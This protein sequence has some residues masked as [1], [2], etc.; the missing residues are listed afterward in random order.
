[1]NQHI[2]L[3]KY[4]Q[5][6]I[7]K[8]ISTIL[9][10]SIIFSFFG[11]K[12]AYAASE[13]VALQ[14][15]KS[16]MIDDKIPTEAIKYANDNF[17]DVLYSSFGYYEHLSSNKLENYSLGKPFVICALDGI[18][19]EIYYFPICL[20]DEI[21]LV[22][23]VIG[24][25]QGY[26]LSA[27]D[28]LVGLLTE[29]KY[30]KS[31]LLLFYKSNDSIKVKTNI[32]TQVADQIQTSNINYNNIV[33]NF[34]NASW[35]ICVQQI[36]DKIDQMKV[37][38]LKSRIAKA[39]D[40]SSAKEAYSPSFSTDNLVGQKGSRICALY[41]PQG[42][43]ALPICWAASVATI[44][45]YR[46]GTNYSAVNVCD[47]MGLS[48]SGQN[49]NVKQEALAKYGI[50]YQKT[51]SQLNLGVVRANIDN[52]YPIAMSCSNDN[53]SWHA[54]T[55]YGYTIAT[56]NNYIV[57]HNSGTQS[58]MT[59]R[60]IASGTTFSYNNSTYTWVKSLHYQ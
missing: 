52:K 22:V 36:S 12:T 31:E 9:L 46:L 5:H 10:F 4:N 44:V 1:M 8:I 34:E 27:S 33:Q 41:N 13:T 45:N 49:I 20:G 30:L 56:N 3:K 18:Q 48:Y 14:N 25:D 2:C 16:Q 32:H 26:T 21:V 55:L 37:I 19:E 15:Y 17:E 53:N 35:D 29:N 51:I 47:R 58:S 60:Y 23:S 57:V 28:E 50:S 39:L 42:Q 43:G 24:T 11:F 7:C 6:K 38:N 59:I 54:T 40:D